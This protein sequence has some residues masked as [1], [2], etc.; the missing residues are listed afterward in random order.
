M[1]GSAS[2]IINKKTEI[3][4]EL[5]ILGILRSYYVS[6]IY[7]FFIMMVWFVVVFVRARR[8]II[9]KIKNSSLYIVFI[10]YASI[11]GSLFYTTREITRTM[12]YIIPT[13]IAICMGYLIQVLYK[14]KSIFKTIYLICTLNCI[15]T[16]LY[17]SR[18]LGEIGEIQGLRKYA[19]A[20]VLEVTIALISFFIEKIIYKRI[21][22][23]LVIDY[24]VL[25][26]FIV[27]VGISL[28]RSAFGQV[29][30]GLMTA[31]ILVIIFDRKRVKTRI[32]VGTVLLF[33]TVLVIFALLP[34]DAMDTFNDKMDNTQQ[35]LDA[36][37]E[38]HSAG[39]A[40][41]NWRGFEMQEARE[42]W[43]HNNNGFEIVFGEGMGSSI[44][45]KYIPYS[46]DKDLIGNKVAVL[47]NGYYGMLIYG[48]IFGVI[49]LICL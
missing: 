46:W 23:G 32:I 37:Q 45:F 14:N 47:H 16:I 3:I 2:V 31:L 20:F 35:E 26:L 44:H 25:T 30:I 9:P 18:H 49:A 41:K 8:I 13:L 43:S 38:Y 27:K 5:L 15:H 29:G 34:E 7:T 36:N 19:S 22:F 33:A 11:Y 10:L 40:M 4:W 17:V 39:E 24:I 42:Q 12:F 28:Q 48:G 1:K 21:I 6:D